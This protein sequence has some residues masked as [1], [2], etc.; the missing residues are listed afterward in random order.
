MRRLLLVGAAAY[1]VWIL[2]VWLRPDL[3]PLTSYVSELSAEDQSWS[4]LF[5]AS[6]A[7]A[8]SAIALAALLVL[9]RAGWRLR[10]EQVGWTWP[11]GWVALATFGVT[12]VLDALTPMA[13]AVT[14]D[15]WCAT[16][17]SA[18]ALPLH[19]QLHTV[20]SVVANAA[21]LVAALA[22]ARVMARRR[23]VVA[24]IGWGLVATIVI[25]TLWT[26]GEIIGQRAHLPG[27]VLLGLA[28]RL[29]LSAAALFIGWVALDL[30]AA[31][32]QP[33]RPRMPRAGSS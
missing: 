13:C 9:A 25:G 31:A 21:L 27:P 26:L 15:S 20:T 18:G 4:L 7:L 29:T 11:L 22:L 1:A 32:A 2:S 6:D 12:T 33:R 17:E 8:G 5:R 14:H 28:Q 23:P 24:W 19:H 10:P 3:S 16:R 30:P